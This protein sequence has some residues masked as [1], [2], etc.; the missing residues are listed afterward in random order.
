MTESLPIAAIV[1]SGKHQADD[2]LIAFF[3]DLTTRGWKIRGLVRGPADS[4]DDCATRTV[5][6]V[7]TGEIYPI[8]QNLGQGS[9]ACCLDPG[10]LIAAAVVLHRAFE[11]QV[12]LALVNRFGILEADGKGFA[13]E[14]LSFMG[15]GIPMLTVV[16]QTYL[17]A[18]RHFTGGLAHEMPA[19]KEALYDWARSLPAAQKWPLAEHAA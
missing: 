15:E 14:M 6:D 13:Q 12:D 2:L 8:S 7:H 17:E 4:A 19:T 18:W 10:A 5:L 3:N 1:H 16:S 9:T 11:A